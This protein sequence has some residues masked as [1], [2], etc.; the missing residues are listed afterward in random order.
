[1][2]NIAQLRDSFVW[3]NF[4]LHDWSSSSLIKSCSINE[5]ILFHWASRSGEMKG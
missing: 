2:P 4:D 1:M 3:S 5:L